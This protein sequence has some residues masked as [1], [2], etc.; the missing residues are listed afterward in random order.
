ME[1]KF[2]QKLNEHNENTHELLNIVNELM[3]IS[4]AQLES[5]NPDLSEHIADIAEKCADV[6]G[7]MTEAFEEEHGEELELLQQVLEDRQ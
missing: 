3:S 2:A 5:G 7:K 1:K 6:V 4:K